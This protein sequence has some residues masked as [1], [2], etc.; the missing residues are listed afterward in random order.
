MI[1]VYR[2]L[3]DDGTMLDYRKFDNP[4]DA[5]V[6]YAE[7][8]QTRTDSAG[9]VKLNSN[10]DWVTAGHYRTDKDWMFEREMNLGRLKSNE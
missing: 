9:V 6:Y 4:N 7:L 10:Q 1:R 2:K 8:C 5:E 3:G